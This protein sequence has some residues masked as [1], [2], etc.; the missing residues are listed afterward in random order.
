MSLDAR[1]VLRLARE[2]AAAVA[3]GC[4]I[5]LAVL[6]AGDLPAGEVLRRAGVT[7]A[8]A[9]TQVEAVTVQT[10]FRG[11]SAA[12]GGFELRAL[13][14]APVRIARA[15]GDHQI[16]VEHLLRGTLEDQ[17]GE[18]ARTLNSLGVDPGTVVAELSDLLA[19]A[20]ARRATAAAPK[21]MPAVAARPA[22]LP[23]A[24]L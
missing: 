13:L 11:R 7:L 14:Q 4:H 22:E 8:R 19:A 18:A 5:V 20:A 17:A 9:R 3:T 15:R 1:R 6:R 10:R 24:G 2:E 16:E 23:Q 21:S 12:P